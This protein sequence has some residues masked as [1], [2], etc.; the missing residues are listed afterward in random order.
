[1]RAE[2]LTNTQSFFM[3]ANMLQVSTS[4]KITWDRM[5]TTAMDDKCGNLTPILAQ[6]KSKYKEE[7]EKEE[8]S[9]QACVDRK[10]KT[11]FIS[12]QDTQVIFDLSRQRDLSTRMDSC[13]TS[14]LT[15]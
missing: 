11:S 14:S 7:E 5:T 2:E 6:T 10:S 9:I 15:T 12:D 3:P 8:V 13:F 1:M 4:S